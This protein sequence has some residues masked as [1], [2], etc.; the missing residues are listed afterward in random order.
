MKRMNYIKLFR[1]AAL[2]LIVLAVIA[3]PLT[4]SPAGAQP[5]GARELPEYEL[6]DI[7]IY[8]E[9][10]NLLEISIED[11]AEAHEGELCTCVACVFRVV[12]AAISELYEEDI[13]KQGEIKVTYHQPSD[14]HKIAFESLLGAKNCTLEM[15]PGTSA[16][17]LTRENYRYE[18][19]STYT[20]TTF[21]TQVREDIFPEGYFEL[22]EKVKNQTATSEEKTEFAEQWSDLRDNFLTMELWELFE[23]IEAPEEEE[24]EGFPA[25]AVLFGVLVVG[26]I[27]FTLTRRGRYR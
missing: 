7:S 21:E 2:A 17:H 14:G 19:S 13:P 24:G 18:F 16:K 23:G 5:P 1:I 27:V 22:R 15:P 4:A 11:V 9:D 10:G 8:D 6:E 12:Q 26:V 20:E 25:G 3:V